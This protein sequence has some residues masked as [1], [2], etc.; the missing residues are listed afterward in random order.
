VSF[1]KPR[2][3]AT[4]ASILSIGEAAAFALR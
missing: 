3:T 1:F 4:F 2:M